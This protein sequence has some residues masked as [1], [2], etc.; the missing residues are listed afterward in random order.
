MEDAVRTYSRPSP[1]QNHRPA[2]CRG[3][4]T[5]NDYPILRIDTNQGVYGIGEVRDA[6]TT[7]TRSSSELA[8]GAEPC[9]V[10]MIFRAI[11]PFW[12]FGPRRAAACP[13]SSSP[14]GTWSARCMACRAT[15]S[16]AASTETTSGSMP[17]RPRLQSRRRRR[18]AERVLGRKQMG[19]TFIK[20]DVGMHA[21]QG[22][23]RGSGG[24]ATP[25]EYGLGRRWTARGCADGTQ[26]TDQGIARVGRNRAAGA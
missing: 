2:P 10:D 1:S 12:R 19:L 25:F 24:S 17:T 14:S 21:L 13:A 23:S 18:Y 26:L 9:N 3:V 20:F 16:W 22:L 11:K 15:S 5:I 4:Q 7:R 6:G 8:A